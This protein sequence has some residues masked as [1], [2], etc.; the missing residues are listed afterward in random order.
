ADAAASEPTTARQ[1]RKCFME[2]TGS[3]SLFGVS[4]G[5]RAWQRIRFMEIECVPAPI[6]VKGRTG[7]SKH[8]GMTVLP[9]RLARRLLATS[10]WPRT[11]SF[12]SPERV[13]LPAPVAGFH[14]G[15]VEVD[16]ILRHPKRLSQQTANLLRELPVHVAAQPTDAADIHEGRV[17][18]LAG[19]QNGSGADGD[20]DVL[21]RLANGLGHDLGERRK[22]RLPPVIGQNEC[23]IES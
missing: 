1:T 10:H 5:A 3:T 11:T 4:R 23:G 8:P 19:H 20:H 2:L 21:L 22:Q 17:L 12:A 14:I 15:E 16:A 7:A 18:R 6:G 9:G 13:P